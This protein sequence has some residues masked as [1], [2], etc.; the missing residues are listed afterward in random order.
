[1]SLLVYNVPTD[2]LKYLKEQI[3]HLKSR[4]LEISNP[5]ARL[6]MDERIKKLEQFLTFLQSSASQQFQI[7]EMTNRAE[8]GTSA[9][10]DIFFAL[11]KGGGPHRLQDENL[12]SKLIDFLYPKDDLRK[13]KAYFNNTSISSIFEWW[14]KEKRSEDDVLRGLVK[15][16]GVPE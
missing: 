8:S 6:E 14:E 12:K 15:V 3:D 13:E 5:N 4:L 10:I 7:F 9:N 16:S 2:K 1:M 11:A